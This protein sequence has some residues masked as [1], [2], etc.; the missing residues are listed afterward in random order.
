MNLQLEAHLFENGNITPQNKLH[1]IMVNIQRIFIEE[2]Q[3]NLPHL[4]LPLSV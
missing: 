2:L 1:I 4:T 3:I